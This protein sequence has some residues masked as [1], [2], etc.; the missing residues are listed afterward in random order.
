MDPRSNFLWKKLHVATTAL[1]SGGAGGLHSIVLNGLTTAG[2]ATVYDG[3]DNT[4]AVVAI[5]HLNP[6]ASISVQPLPF[7]YDAEI[8][9]G[10]YIEY[11]Q[12]LVADLTVMYI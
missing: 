2:D 11:D 7:L 9:T 5:L 8:E 1:V 10:I 4:G 12:N 6:A 3:V